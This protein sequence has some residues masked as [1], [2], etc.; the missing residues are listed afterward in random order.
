[1]RDIPYAPS[2]TGPTSA[3][4]RL[5]F[6]EKKNQ[7]TF[8]SEADSSNAFV[9]ANEA[10]AFGRFQAKPP[11]NWSAAFRVFQAKWPALA[12]L[13]VFLLCAASAWLAWQRSL[14][15]PYRETW[16][17]LGAIFLASF[18]AIDRLL[19]TRK[20]FALLSLAAAAAWAGIAFCFSNDMNVIYTVLPPGMAVS[21][22]P[23]FAA[24]TGTAALLAHLSPLRKGLAD[25]GFIALRL[26]SAEI[27][28]VQ[29]TTRL[30]PPTYVPNPRGRSR[31]RF[32]SS[33]GRRIRLPV[34]SVIVIALAFRFGLATTII[35]ALWTQLRNVPANQYTP[36]E[37]I[38]EQP[39]SSID[40][41]ANGTSIPL[42]FNPN[43]SSLILT[44]EDADQFGVVTRPSRHN[45]YIKIGDSYLA[46]TGATLP[47]VSIGSARFANLYVYVAQ[48]GALSESR[49]GPAIAAAA[50]L[51]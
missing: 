48:P 4:E 29:G 34:F 12:T 1:M 37:R 17:L 42:A 30:N 3:E 15:Q 46:V 41:R 25:R 20:G 49:Y 33:P 32:G 11:M 23:F 22:R 31:S 40:A 16:L 27:D 43:A 14:L 36:A 28:I 13:E 21:S 38:Q 2:G 26:R 45:T 19:L 8:V 44:A 10:R 9:T 7:K 47:A 50:S 6:F 51:R 24:L 39:T 35:I 18:W 5:F